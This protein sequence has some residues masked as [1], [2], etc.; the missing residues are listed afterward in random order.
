MIVISFFKVHMSLFGNNTISRATSIQ[1]GLLA[2]WS[3]C[4][5][6]VTSCRSM[7]YPRCWSLFISKG[8]LGQIIWNR[9][10][11][12]GIQKSC[13]TASYS[14]E[15]I[16]RFETSLTLLAYLGISYFNCSKLIHL[17]SILALWFQLWSFSYL[18]RWTIGS[19]IVCSRYYMI[20][21]IRIIHLSCSRYDSDGLLL[22]WSSW[23]SY[24]FH[25]CA[26]AR[27][28]SLFFLN[29]AIGTFITAL[30]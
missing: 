10:R 22:S 5:C 24:T 28:D 29:E 3:K 12:G 6:G 23:E 26:C 4:W 18:R 9:L 30:G 11:N 20:S 16:V 7:P 19:E 21:F 25:L 8:L 15:I 2:G 17:L 13:C 27:N 14:L 1:K